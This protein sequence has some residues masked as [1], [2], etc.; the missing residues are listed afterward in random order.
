MSEPILKPE[1]HVPRIHYVLVDHENVQ[2]VDIGL[3][4]RADVRLFVFVGAQQAKLL[5]EIAI[6][7]Q[8]MGDRAKYIRASAVGANALDFHIAYYVGRLVAA[9]PTGLFYIV[10]KDKG[11]D[12]LLAHLK[13][14]KVDA[15][16]VER[17]VEMPIFKRI[18]SEKRVAEKVATS[19][20][21]DAGKNTHPSSGKGP[22]AASVKA[23]K[24]PL[25]RVRFIVDPVH[26]PVAATSKSVS[27]PLPVQAAKP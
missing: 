18:N 27:S 4:D 20:A 16:R 5:S 26:S 9:D 1:L 25:K 21:C 23:T 13:A 24:Q 19:P 10:S 14:A 22:Q 12:P 7:M 17:I 6:P 3:L 8:D 15:A 11:Y 2:P